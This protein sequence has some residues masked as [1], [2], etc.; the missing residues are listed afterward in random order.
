M[1]YAD[2]VDV[3]SVSDGKCI[4]KVPEADIAKWDDAIDEYYDNLEDPSHL[5]DEEK[6]WDSFIEE[7][8]NCII[9]F[10]YL[11]EHGGNNKHIQSTCASKYI[12]YESYAMLC[13]TRCFKTLRS[14]RYLLDKEIGVDCLALVRNIFENYLHIIYVKSD[15]DRLEDIVD[16]VVGLK[17]GTHEYK[18][19][20]NGQPDIRTIID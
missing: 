6:E 20:N 3:N 11:L 2:S 5:T 1:R 15:P 18:K 13:A 7:L 12:N 17:R 10:G 19:K 9:M 16:A 4:V 8:A 14:I